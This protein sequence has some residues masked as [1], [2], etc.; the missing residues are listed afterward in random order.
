MDIYP[1]HLLKAIL[2]ED[3]ELMENL[4][5]YE[6][7][8]EDFALAEYACTSKINAQEIVRRGLNLVRKE[9]M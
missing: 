4:G 1:V 3:I 2:I 8:P 9:T 6:V 7:A 5:I